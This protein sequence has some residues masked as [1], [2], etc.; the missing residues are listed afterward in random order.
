[1]QAAV[2]AADALNAWF[3][4]HLSTPRAAMMAPPE[5]RTRCEKENDRAD[6]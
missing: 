5:Q 6:D 4:E 1:M 3:E 2:E